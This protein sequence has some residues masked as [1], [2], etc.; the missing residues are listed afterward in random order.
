MPDNNLSSSH[1][2]LA[3]EPLKTPEPESSR[4]MITGLL[5]DK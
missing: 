4:A 1:E 5:T 3:L 2:N